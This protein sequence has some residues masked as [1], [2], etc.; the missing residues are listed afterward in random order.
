MPTTPSAE[1][2]RSQRSAIPIADAGRLILWV[3]LSLAAVLPFLAVEFPPLYDFYHWVFQGH[4]TR[5][6]L[7]GGPEGAGSVDSIYRL[8]GAPIPDSVTPFGIAMLNLWFPALVAGRVFLALCVLLF[9]YGWAYMVRSVQ[10]RP[11]VIEFLGFPWAFGYFMYKGYDSYLVS[12]AVAFLALGILHRSTVQGARAPSRVSLIT[13]ILLGVVLF[14]C[15]LIGWAVFALGSGLYTL[16]LLRQR[17]GK[18]SLLL[19]APLV[20]GMVMLVVYALYERGQSGGSTVLL[21][22]ALSDKILSLVQSLLLFI[23]TDPFAS[24]LPLFWLNVAGL[25]LFA[26]II[27]M[28][29]DLE[30]TLAKRVTMPLLLLGTLL[31]VLSLVIPFSRVGG[32]QY[33]DGR[34]VLPGVLI[35]LAALRFKK[36]TFRTGGLVACIILLVMGFHLVEYQRASESLREIAAVTT[37]TI[38]PHVPVLSLTVNEDALHGCEEDSAGLSIGAPTLKWFDLYLLMERGALRANIMETSLVRTSFSSTATPDLNV[39]VMSPDEV[40]AQPPLGGRFAASYQFVEAFGCRNDLGSVAQALT[41]QY[42]SVT[43]GNGFVILRRQR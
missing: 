34:F 14:L 11:T 26:A 23:R 13:L 33:P 27:V 4:V 9:A 3:V 41:P 10:Q 24:I 21:Y 35:A 29:I 1:I 40:R 16:W 39:L 6:L 12:L 37:A 7:F 22:N 15:H 42:T 30:P 17:Q 36:F 25:L 20:P 32:L 28:T 19:L 43:H 38:P 18:G 2:T 31:L 8:S 5:T